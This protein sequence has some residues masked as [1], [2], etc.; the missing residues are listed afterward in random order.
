MII[1]KILFWVLLS[2]VQLLSIN[3]NFINW[4]TQK[5]SSGIISVDISSIISMKIISIL[6]ND[7]FLIAPKGKTPRASLHEVISNTRSE[8]HK[9]MQV[10]LLSLHPSC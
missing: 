10:L 1:L 4:I 9:Y 6:S 8:S 3:I 5:V 7:F 2:N